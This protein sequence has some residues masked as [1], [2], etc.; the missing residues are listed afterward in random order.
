MLSSCASSAPINRIFSS[1]G[2]TSRHGIASTS[3][4]DCLIC[5]PCC[6][7]ILLP[8]LPVCTSRRPLPVRERLLRE[9][10]SRLHS[11]PAP[12]LS[13]RWPRYTRRATT[14]PRTRRGED[15]RTRESTISAGLPLLLLPALPIGL[16][17]RLW[18]RL[19]C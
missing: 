4:R 3:C 2:Q 16:C 5:Y 11:S 6:R 8:I 19:L 12:H 18:F 1:M 7:S 14:S 10:R 9:V 15:L 17:R 13:R